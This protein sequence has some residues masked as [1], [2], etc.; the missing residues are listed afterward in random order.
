M[1]G[2]KYACNDDLKED[3]FG[4]KVFKKTVSCFGIIGNTLLL[5]YILL[6]TFVPSIESIAVA[7]AAPGGLAS[8]AWLLMVGI[9]LIRF[10]GDGGLTI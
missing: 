5:A 3:L 6:V 2:T 4:V 1:T 7:I 9:K 10:H 8:L